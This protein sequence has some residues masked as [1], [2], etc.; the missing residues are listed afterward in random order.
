MSQQEKLSETSWT[1]TTRRLA[2]NVVNGF[3]SRRFICP[4]FKTEHVIPNTPVIA[5]N[6][7]KGIYFILYRGNVYFFELFYMVEEK[8]YFFRFGLVEEGKDFTNF[9][10]V[11]EI[12]EDAT[13]RY[14]YN[15]DGS[16]STIDRIAV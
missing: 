2:L 11:A 5:G 13:I 9:R 16:L 3:K 10:K 15:P 12:S 1:R 4:I 6:N 14:N 7:G 8:G